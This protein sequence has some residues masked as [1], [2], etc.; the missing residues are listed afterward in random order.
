MHQPFLQPL[1]IARLL[2]GFLTTL[3]LTSLGCHSGFYNDS[4]LRQSIDPAQQN[5][6]IGNRYDNDRAYI[7]A[8]DA[9]S[10][11]V[12]TGD[13]VVLTWFA[14][15]AETVDLPPFAYNQPS[16]GKITVWPKRT[17]T[18]ILTA[19]R[20]KGQGD[21]IQVNRFLTVF[22]EAVI[23]PPTIWSFRADRNGVRP[24][25]H[26]YLKWRVAGC[27]TVRISTSRGWVADRPCFI[28]EDSI[29]IYAP[30]TTQYTLELYNS[31]EELMIL[32][33]TTLDIAQ[34]IKN[35]VI[36]RF[37]TDEPGRQIVEAGSLI[38]LSWNTTDSTEVRINPDPS[39][40]GSLPDLNRLPLSGSLQAR[41]TQDTTYVLNATSNGKTVT[42]EIRLKVS[43]GPQINQFEANPP[44][45]LADATTTLQWSSLNCTR[46]SLTTPQGTT[47]V[48]CSGS[49]PIQLGQSTSFTL[50]ATSSSGA[51]QTKQF[52]V[53]VDPQPKS[54]TIESFTTT[55]SRIKAGTEVTLTWSTAHAAK[56]EILG[57]QTPIV[58]ASGQVKVIPNGTTTL[59]MRV[60]N[61][62][63]S[64]PIREW[65]ITIEVYNPSLKIVAFKAT[66]SRVP[67]NG[68]T[69]L[70]WET[71]HCSRVVI[72]DRSDRKTSLRLDSTQDCSGSLKVPVRKGATF[73]LFVT[74][75]DGQTAS[76]EITVMAGADDAEALYNMMGQ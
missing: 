1:W 58:A 29:P 47:D 74:G 38:T 12:R 32:G 76:Q 7:H 24:N 9:S 42:R 25:E 70:K 23:G 43:P 3:V 34:E 73:S 71:T 63:E 14:P 55:A 36:T 39:F 52:I 59:T 18:Y 50:V 30:E 17:T 44:R 15:G 56:I 8:F 46:A 6:W 69:T 48:A 72:Q 28:W 49:L 27:T 60:Y 10:Q 61:Q 64:S 51:T 11:Y 35:P 31:K 41:P 53:A 33:S 19:Y 37:E 57:L 75:S 16:T 62:G 45:I 65:P 67:V 5:D 26:T 68:T 20:N 54:A 22:A 4:N 40:V 2:Q 66:D 21:E 13:P